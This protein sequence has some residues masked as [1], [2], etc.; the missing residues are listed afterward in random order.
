[1]ARRKEFKELVGCGRNGCQ[2]D[3]W[4]WE[5]G[6]DELV[7]QK[8]LVERS[9]KGKCALGDRNITG[10]VGLERQKLKSES[11]MGERSLRV[12]GLWG[13]GI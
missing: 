10:T 7:G 2:K 1:M 3:S 8:T 13:K 4:H 9:V 6:E 5:K 12:S 11:A